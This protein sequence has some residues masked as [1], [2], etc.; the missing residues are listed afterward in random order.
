MLFEW[1]AA[2]DRSNRR[3]HNGLD[4]KTASRIFADPGSRSRI[5]RVVGDETRWQTVGMVGDQLLLVAHTWEEHNGE[6]TI[7]IISARKASKHEGR[8]YFQQADE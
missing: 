5:E 6:E 1:D 7:R 2:K 3:K 8:R 4:F